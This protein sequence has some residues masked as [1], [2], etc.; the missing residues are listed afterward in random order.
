MNSPFFNQGSFQREN[1]NFYKRSRS[2]DRT[3][4]NPRTTPLINKP[5]GLQNI[6]ATCYMNATLQ[7]FYHCKKLTQYLSGN[8]YLNDNIT[9]PYNSITSEY[10]KLVKELSYKNGE[11]DYAP[12]NFKEILG[13]K[14]PLFKGIAAN[15]SK[16]LILFLEEEMARE[17]AIN[18]KRSIYN[19]NK[20][21]QGFVDQSNE[22]A[23]F[24]EAVKEFEKQK[25]IIKDL[26]YFT[27]KTMSICQNCKAKLY[28]FQV[29]NFLIFPL[30]KTY[31][32]SINMSNTM[33]LNN[34]IN[35]MNMNN[36]NLFGFGNFN[37]NTNQNNNMIMRK[38]ADNINNRIINSNMMN[39]FNN[40]NYRPL[41]NPMNFMNQ[42]MNMNMN[43]NIMN[44]HNNF[45]N[46][47][48]LNNNMINMNNFNNN[49]KIKTKIEPS[50]NKIK[51]NKF[52][53]GNIY[54][55]NEDNTPIG[56]SFRKSRKKEVENN[57]QLVN[58]VQNIFFTNNNK[59]N[60]SNNNS[61]NFRYNNNNFSNINNFRNNNN[62]HFDNYRRNNNNQYPGLFGSGGRGPSDTLIYG[63][64][65]NRGPKITLDQC[66]ESYLK[67]DYLTGD[68][69]QYCNKCGVL[70]D[71][72][73]STYIYSSPNILIL[74]LNYGKNL[75]FKCDVQFDE[76]INIAKYIES[77][78]DAMPTRYRLLGAIVHIGPS[79][80]G[81]HFIAF[82]RGID[83]PEKWYNLN[84]SIV[85]EAAFSDIKS[86]GIPYVLFYENTNKY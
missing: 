50:S 22:M 53:N 70:S 6:G 85:T 32:D 31:Q 71:A 30:Q 55:K 83:N 81:G 42:Q 68:N 23:T 21:S 4:L 67:P 29:M 15:D 10:I 84:D 79:S 12:Y 2:W 77:K 82:C 26:F 72:F 56:N 38:S 80:M 13:I 8:K 46:F 28:N 34:M 3:L 51:S 18:D 78:Y 9:V 44:Y 59:N 41:V 47:N 48:N 36:N 33:V 58:N 20:Q 7:C 39:N 37:M 27:I 1:N 25:S 62:Y 14:N 5:K 61:N 16:D 49:D 57:N 86:V 11:K 63:N 65:I 54:E 24:K 40:N 45:N 66:F 73:Y 35:N 19:N 60:F 43:N 75:V 76:Y 64:I 52:F 17:L 74:I 69:K